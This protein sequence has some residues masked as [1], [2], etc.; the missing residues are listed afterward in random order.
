[1]YGLRRRLSLFPLIAWCSE[2]T[3]YPTCYCGIYVKYPSADLFRAFQVALW[4]QKA[5]REKGAPVVWDYHAILVLRLKYA[6][7][8][9]AP[10]SSH[11]DEDENVGSVEGCRSWVYDFDTSITPVP[12]S[13]HGEFFVLFMYCS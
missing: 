13:W 7:K 10:S 2:S 4:E 6:A 11:G 3:R 5:A 8:T 9:T 1:M 12:C